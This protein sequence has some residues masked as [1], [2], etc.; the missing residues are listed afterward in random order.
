MQPTREWPPLSLVIKA[1]LLVGSLDLLAAFIDLYLSTGRNPFVTV[2]RYIASGLFGM[3][4]F[5][6]S[7]WMIAA[8]LLFHFCF[9]GFFTLLFFVLYINVKGISRYWWLTGMVY[10]LFIWVVMNRVVVPASR[11][12]AVSAFNW[13]KAVKA[14]AILT[15]LIGLPLSWIAKK[16]YDRYPKTIW[17]ATAP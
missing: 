1:W 16:Y 15:V 13:T 12:P 4:A 5:T 14:V 11:V 7:G 8:G 10:S 2:P 17:K 3:E 6:G 9:A